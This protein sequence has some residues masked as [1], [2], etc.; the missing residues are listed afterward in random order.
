M[1]D[2]AS[3][4]QYV[5]DSPKKVRADMDLLWKNIQIFNMP[6]TPEFLEGY[7]FMNLAKYAFD[8]FEE[9]LSR[10]VDDY[11]FDDNENFILNHFYDFKN[12]LIKNYINVIAKDFETI[13]TIKVSCTF[14][15]KDKRSVSSKERNKIHHQLNTKKMKHL[16]IQDLYEFG[17]FEIDLDNKSMVVEIAGMNM[18]KL[19]YSEVDQG[20]AS[21]PLRGF[22]KNN[23]SNIKKS[24]N[25]NGLD[26]QA[27]QGAL[28]LERI[29]INPAISEEDDEKLLSPLSQT[30][31]ELICQLEYWLSEHRETIDY[32]YMLS[33][34]MLPI[35]L[36]TVN[37]E[38]ILQPAC[39]ISG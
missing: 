36:K 20:V 19:E 6:N 39:L 14:E 10:T 31:F 13:S 7:K 16:C 26:L 38:S 15:E 33:V 29:Q 28:T 30:D 32:S 9:Q 35:S 5:I 12:L 22:I 4:K 34:D 1:L 21:A 3:K 25:K 11:L 18:L 8:F 17:K 2:S 23:V 37:P 24:T 27:Q